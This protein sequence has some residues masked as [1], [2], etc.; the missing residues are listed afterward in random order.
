MFSKLYNS[1][2]QPFGLL[3][4]TI[5]DVYKFAVPQSRKFTRCSCFNV[6]SKLVHK[7][8]SI[9]SQLSEGTGHTP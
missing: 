9:F 4:Q 3:Q 2:R 5:M 7:T 1:G 6:A 8:I